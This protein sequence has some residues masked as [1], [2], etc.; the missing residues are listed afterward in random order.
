MISPAPPSPPPAGRSSSAY[1]A[2]GDV[3][4]EYDASS[5]SRPVT[6]ASSHS[7]YTHSTSPPTSTTQTHAHPPGDGSN[8]HTHTHYHLVEP[9]LITPPDPEPGLQQQQDAAVTGLGLDLGEPLEYGVDL[10]RR[11][12]EFPP[13][14]HADIA[15]PKEEDWAAQQGLYASLVEAEDVAAAAAVA[16][17][18][19]PRSFGA[20]TTPP[21]ARRR[22]LQPQP[23]D[24]EYSLA[25]I[26]PIAFPVPTVM[27]AYGR[28]PTSPGYPTRLP[29]APYTA[30]SSPGYS[31]REPLAPAPMPP[32]PGYSRRE[33]LAPAPMPPSPQRAMY[34]PPAQITT[35]PTATARMD[36]RTSQ[37][38]ASG[39]LNARVDT[40]AGQVKVRG[41]FCCLR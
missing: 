2:V 21:S 5:S 8:P 19:S 35:Q 27:S 4:A 3:Y 24:S 16:V 15:M 39:R 20:V 7:A 30:P 31:R 1:A 33:P 28:Q 9:P 25:H 10:P 17:A 11:S 37:H 40:P 32:S 36:V 6:A 34:P 22:S 23:R 41:C 26:E 14:N 12:F 29:P 38:S 18:A 13:R